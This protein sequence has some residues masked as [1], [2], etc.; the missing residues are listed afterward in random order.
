MNSEIE[1]IKGTEIVKETDTVKEKDKA[2][3]RQRALALHEYEYADLGLYEWVCSTSLELVG[4]ATQ[5]IIRRATQEAH[6]SDFTRSKRV[7]ACIDGQVYECNRRAVPSEFLSTVTG[8]TA[9][10]STSYVNTTGRAREMLSLMRSMHAEVRVLLKIMEAEQLERVEEDRILY[11][12]RPTRQG[13]R[14]GNSRPCRYCQ[15]ILHHYGVRRILYTDVTGDG[16]EMLC[17]LRARTPKL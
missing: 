16:Q 6:K 17:E 14:V 8:L 4:H 5:G 11:V 12:V 3:R 9:A 13:T 15:I 10:G 2:V 7:V 1:V